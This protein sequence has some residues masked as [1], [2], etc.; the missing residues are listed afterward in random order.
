MQRRWQACAKAW[1]SHEAVDQQGDQERQQPGQGDCQQRAEA[2]EEGH[3][4][5]RDGKAE[6][7]RPEREEGEAREIAVS[8]RTRW[9]GYRSLCQRAPGAQPDGDRRR[10]G[11]VDWICA[12]LDAEVE[13]FRHRVR[14]EARRRPTIDRPIGSR[15]RAR[16]C[17]NPRRV[18]LEV[19]VDAHENERPKEHSKYCRKDRHE[20][21]DVGQ[22]RVTGRHDQADD[23]IM[24]AASR[25]R[26]GCRGSTR[27]D[28]RRGLRTP[29]SSSAG[30]NRVAPP[31]VLRCLVGYFLVAQNMSANSLVAAS[32]SAA[33][34][35]STPCLFLPASFSRFQTFVWRS[36]NAARC[37]GL[38]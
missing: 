20:L 16:R 6:E 18:L 31:P 8:G 32:R 15:R 5:V 26:S 22:V 33:A 38:K 17:R 3:H 29:R 34:C 2:D 21:V 4:P 28:G 14:P 9:G 25:R 12:T 37:S 13:T 27:G 35:A 23:K 10:Q 19:Q 7:R 1:P 24:R 11:R 30:R 36:G